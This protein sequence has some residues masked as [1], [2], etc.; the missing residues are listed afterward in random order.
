MY[1]RFTF[2]CSRCVSSRRLLCSKRSAN[3]LL[4]V[5]TSAPFPATFVAFEEVRLAVLSEPLEEPES[6]DPES[7][8]EPEPDSSSLNIAF[9]A[10]AGG[11]IA[12]P[13]EGETSHRLNARAWIFPPPGPSS[14][15]RRP[16]T[17]ER[18]PR[19]R[20]VCR[21]SVRLPQGASWFFRQKK[22]FSAAA[23]A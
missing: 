23:A 7:E 3:F 1:S 21:T 17:N 9:A 8:P 13:D 6:S 4:M 12:N 2:S 14:L 18:G 20:R 19:V 16:R 5:S 11:D 22:F 10:A 15:A